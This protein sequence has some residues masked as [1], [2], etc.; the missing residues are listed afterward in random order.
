MKRVD[1]KKYNILGKVPEF[2]STLYPGENNSVCEE[3]WKFSHFLDFFL[4]EAEAFFSSEKQ[5]RISSSVW[6]EDGVEE[7]SALI[8]QA[9]IIEDKKLITIQQLREEYVERVRVLRMAREYLLETRNLS[10]NMERYKRISEYD[11]L[12][13]LYNKSTYI[14]LLADEI[15]RAINVRS[16]LSLLVIDIDNFKSVND[17]FGHIAGDKILAGIGNILSSSIRKGDIAARYGGEEFVILAPNTSTA[18][19]VKLAEKLRKR[20]DSQVFEQP[21]HVT[22]SVGL[23]TYKY[24]ESSTDFFQR[25]DTALYDAKRCTKNVVK[26]R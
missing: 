8:A 19:A 15:E 25:A 14:N 24:S 4:D 9:I 21:K 2:Y 3:P 17:T 6:Q 7:N 12:T 18:N 22:I 23:T 10:N 26:V 11:A 1:E 20:V 16:Q 5:G 13:G